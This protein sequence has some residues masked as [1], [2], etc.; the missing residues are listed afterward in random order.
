MSALT[1]LLLLCIMCVLNIVVASLNILMWR[2][3]YISTVSVVASV[4]LVV[5]LYKKVRSRD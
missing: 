1:L 4:L 2:N 3:V 5:T